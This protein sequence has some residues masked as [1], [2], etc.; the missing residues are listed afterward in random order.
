MIVAHVVSN[1]CSSIVHSKRVVKI[2]VLLAWVT[3][4]QMPVMGTSVFV[5]FEGS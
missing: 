4:S 3:L 5:W 1:G 2:S